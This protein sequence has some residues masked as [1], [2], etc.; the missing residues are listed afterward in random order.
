MA[1]EQGYSKIPGLTRAEDLAL[2]ALGEGG[3]GRF[4]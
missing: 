1:Y 2:R 4:R 3:Q